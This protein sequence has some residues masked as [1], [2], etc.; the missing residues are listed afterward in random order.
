MTLHF[1]LAF[2]AGQWRVLVEQCLVAKQQVAKVTKQQRYTRKSDNSRF[3][4]KIMNQSAINTTFFGPIN[5]NGETYQENKENR[6]RLDHCI[7]AIHLLEHLLTDAVTGM[8]MRV[9][10]LVLTHRNAG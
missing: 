4:V 6:P 5:K 10:L 7:N 8:F 9:Q 2:P 1:G 3:W